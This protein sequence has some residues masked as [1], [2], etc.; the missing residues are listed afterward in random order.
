MCCVLMPVVVLR[1]SG[2]K[3]GLGCVLGIVLI[4]TVIGLLCGLRIGADVCFYLVRRCL[5]T[6]LGRGGLL[7]WGLSSTVLVLSRL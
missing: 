1:L 4:W 2:T 5:S 6:V 7:R 3:C